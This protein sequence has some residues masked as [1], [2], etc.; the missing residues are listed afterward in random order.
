MVLVVICHLIYGQVTSCH[1][2]RGTAMPIARPRISLLV[3][4]VVFVFGLTCLVCSAQDPASI[5]LVGGTSPNE[6]RVEIYV[7]DKGWGTVC[8]NG[9]SYEDAV[10]A[11]RQ[12]GFPGAVYATPNAYFGG[13]SAIPVLIENVACVDSEDSIQQCPSSQANSCSH[14]HDAG[15]VCQVPGYIGCYK[16]VRNILPTQDLPINTNDECREYCDSQGHPYSSTFYS[17]CQCTSGVLAFFYTQVPDRFCNVYCPG[18]NRMLCGGNPSYFTVFDSRQGVCEDVGIPEKGQRSGDL[19]RFG[20]TV[21]FTCDVGYELRGEAEIQCLLAGSSGGVAW[22]RPVPL[23]VKQLTTMLPQTTFNPATTNQLMSTEAEIS[24]ILSMT[25][26][27]PRDLSQSISSGSVAGMS[28]AALLILVICILAVVLFLRR[29]REKTELNNLE[30]QALNRVSDST[31]NVYSIDEGSVVESEMF[32]TLSA[33]GGGIAGAA[34]GSPPTTGNGHVNRGLPSI[35]L[36]ADVELRDDELIS[37]SSDYETTES[38]RGNGGDASR[39]QFSDGAG[40]NTN[41]TEGIRSNDR[42]YF[43]LESPNDIASALAAPLHSQ[44]RDDAKIAGSVEGHYYSETDTADTG[45]QNFGQIDAV[46]KDAHHDNAA[47]SDREDAVSLHSFVSTTSGY[48][49]GGF[50]AVPTGLTEN[51][52]F[53]ARA[54]AL[55]ETSGANAQEETNHLQAETDVAS[56]GRSSGDGNGHEDFKA[57]DS[58]P[59]SPE[60][61]SPSYMNTDF[62]AVPEM[63]ENTLYRSRDNDNESEEFDD[64]I[65]SY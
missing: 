59:L 55:E 38:V 14:D 58:V 54:K 19:F 1:N 41:G 24:P 43:V 63:I 51:T 48:V 7:E 29:R 33:A 56:V 65:Y 52:L 18:N 50:N 61:P 8:D 64:H 25:S 45:L 46:A 35:H 12:L 60:T 31:E 3:A 34:A 21:S 42:Y 2:I 10:V 30:P 49:N 4:V 17:Y 27:R 22:N 9:W 40:P 13:N 39:T 53:K 36:Y 32:G 62:H 44:I 23:C 6:G 11:C 28:V 47:L 57:K 15:V 26:S 5:R 37:P 20:D 16:L